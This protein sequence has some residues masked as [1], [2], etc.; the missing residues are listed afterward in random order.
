MTRVTSVF[1]NLCCAIC[2][3]ALS[4]IVLP[5]DAFAAGGPGGGGGGGSQQADDGR[6]RNL[7]ASDSYVPLPPLTATVQADFRAR[8]LL[9]I[10]A[11]L[12][13][14]DNRLRRRAERSMPLLRDAYVSALSVYAGIHYRYGEVPDAERIGEL[15]QQATDHALGEPG[16]EVLLG[17]IMI[18]TD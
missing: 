16:A 8:G 2:L 12:E 4:P 14:S 18:H 7:T 10:E 11:G 3:I 17:M 5:G 13:I 1:R 9:Q 15:L 6:R